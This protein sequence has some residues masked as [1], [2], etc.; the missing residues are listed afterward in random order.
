MALFKNQY[1]YCPLVTNLEGHWDQPYSE[2]PSDLAE[3]VKKEFVLLDWDE[4]NIAER[5]HHAAQT[6]YQSD[7]VHEAAAYF[8]LDRL[9]EDLQVW[10]KR[11]RDESKSSVVVALRDVADRIEAILEL[12]RDRV[13]SEIQEL[14]RLKI[15]TTHLKS[16]QLDMSLGGHRTTLLVHLAVAS[17]HW[18]ANF[19]PSDNTTAPTNQTVSDWL[20]LRGIGKVMADKMATILRADG[21]PKGPRT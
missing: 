21:L 18:W 19:D 15:D 1:G 2:L 9:G 13:G 3:M 11:A 5:H 17:R 12:D 10:A 4:L 8:E 16:D 20:V 7:P 14:R 6:D